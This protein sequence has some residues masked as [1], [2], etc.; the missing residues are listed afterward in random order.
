M[1]KTVIAKP[2]STESH[3]AKREGFFLNISDEE[4]TMIRTLREQHAINVSQLVRNA[5]R[6]AYQSLQ[7]SQASP[8]AVHPKWSGHNTPGEK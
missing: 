1:T 3:S 4:K 6:E 5:I 8:L 2:R 7:S